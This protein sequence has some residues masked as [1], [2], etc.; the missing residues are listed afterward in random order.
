M[1]RGD[2]RANRATAAAPDVGLA[3]DRF[4]AMPALQPFCDCRTFACG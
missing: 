3:L 4:G 1:A 2:R